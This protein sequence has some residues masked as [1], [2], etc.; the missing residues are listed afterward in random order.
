MQCLFSKKKTKWTFKKIYMIS[1]TFWTS[2]SK[3]FKVLCFRMS[4]VTSTS[5]RGYKNRTFSIIKSSYRKTPTWNKIPPKKHFPFQQLTKYQEHMH[6]ERKMKAFEA[7]KKWNFQMN[8][9][10]LM[11]KLKKQALLKM[12]TFAQE[13]HG[14]FIK[15][16][17]EVL[18]Y[19]ESQ[20]SSF[21]EQPK[22]EVK[23]HWY[24]LSP[25]VTN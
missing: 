3:I 15:F 21:L 12:E 1:A 11:N 24:R 23:D 20:A 25:L 10:Y 9:K 5:K 2:R 19:G 16:S 4:L 13:E 17:L 6:Q 7:F 8:I 22:E 14:V 18:G